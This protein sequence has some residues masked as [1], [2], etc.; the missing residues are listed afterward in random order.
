MTPDLRRIIEAGAKE[1]AREASLLTTYERWDREAAETW[2]ND[3]PERAELVASAGKL[4]VRRKEVEDALAH[5]R[6]ILDG[7]AS[8]ELTQKF[9]LVI[10]AGIKW[11]ECDSRALFC[12]AWSYRYQA[13]A[14][15]AT[16]HSA[17]FFADEAEQCDAERK[18]LEALIEQ[19]RAI[20]GRPSLASAIAKE[21][22]L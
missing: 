2:P 11:L 4:A 17:R 9:R 8:C 20:L 12:R 6:A 15:N 1:H 21:A 3:A 16:A 14:S 10:E 13:S 22:S 7:S 19:A 5:A 18:K